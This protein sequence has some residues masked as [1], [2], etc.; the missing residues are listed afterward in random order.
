VNTLEMMV[1]KGVP[2]WWKW[3]QNTWTKRNYLRWNK[4]NGS[5]GC[6]IEAG[7]NYG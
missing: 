5:T 1:K 6:K 7:D 3:R 2:C 4:V